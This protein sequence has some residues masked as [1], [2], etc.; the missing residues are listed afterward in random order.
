MQSFTQTV[1]MACKALLT[2][3]GVTSPN[4]KSLTGLHVECVCTACVPPTQSSVDPCV[5]PVY[6]LCTACAGVLYSLFGRNLDTGEAVAYSDEHWRNVVA[7]L[8]LTK[9]QVGV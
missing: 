6:C 9:Q 5:P 4:S 2:C 8:Y 1:D 3:F 7:R